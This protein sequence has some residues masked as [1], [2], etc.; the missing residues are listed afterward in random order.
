M[1]RLEVVVRLDTNLEVSGSSG[2]AYLLDIERY[3]EPA[4]LFH[5]CLDPLTVTV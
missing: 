2:K 1:L 3:R 4:S 5:R